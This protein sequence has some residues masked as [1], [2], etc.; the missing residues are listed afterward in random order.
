MKTMAGVV[1]AACHSELRHA[2]V[3]ALAGKLTTRRGRLN[4]DEVEQL[5]RSRRP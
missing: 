4:G 5:V 3:V 1:T 2:V